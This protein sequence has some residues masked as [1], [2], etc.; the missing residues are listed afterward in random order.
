VLTADITAKVLTVSGATAS[1]KTYDGTTTATITG[2]T[3][4]GVVEGDTVSVS[5]GGTFASANVGNGIA[6]AAALSLS[7][8]DSG[9][10]SLTQPE[11]LSANITKAAQTITFSALAS[12]AVGDAPFALT[13]I[14]TSGLAVTYTSSNTG[15]ATIDGSTVT[16]VAAGTTVITASQAGDGNYEAATSVQQTLLVSTAIFAENLGTP[17]ATTAITTY[18]NGT[19]PATFQNKGTLTYSN[20]GQA[21]SADIRSTSASVAADYAGASGGGNAFFSSSTT[22]GSIGFAIEGINA[23]AYKNLSLTYSYRKTSSSVLPSLSVDYWNGNAWQ[24][25]ANTAGDL[26]TQASNASIKWYVA[27]SLSLPA[28]ASIN[29]L[30][31][32][33][34]KSGST[35][36]R[37]DDVKLNGVPK[38]VPVITSTPTASAITYGQTLADSVLSNGVADVAGTFA[39]TNPSTAPNAGVADYGVTFTPTDAAEYAAATL[40]VSVTVNAVSLAEEAITLNRSG[41]GYTA[42]ATGVSGFSYSYSGRNGTT[43]GPS[44]TAPSVAG[45]YTVTASSSDANYS[46]SK[47]ENYFVSGLIAA[48]DG[49]TKPADGSEVKIPLS[50]LLTNDKRIDGSGAVQTTGLTITGVTSGEGNTASIG[51]EFVLFVPS[52]SSPET[53]SYTLS[54]GT[55]TATGTVTVT[56]EGAAPTFTLQI[57]QPGT[58]VQGG[59]QTSVTHNFVGIPNQTLAIEYSTDLSTWHSTGNHSTGATGSFTVTVSAAGSHNWNS[60]FFRARY[61]ANP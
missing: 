40:N 22:N 19:A 24:T 41:N 58:P 47:S 1:N 45:F 15:V 43:Y 29:G 50:T 5:G 48:N 20:G 27:K 18:A 28:G 60:M 56:T 4:V 32:R 57:V 14:S 31:L 25:V 2:A 3:L 33:F 46:G 51:G 23:S 7:G 53:F 55:V 10:Y 13:A 39:F 9:N 54:D 26:F 6:V 42:S 8:A 38:I 59:G 30:K 44:S 34:V 35:E 36:I 52:E 11:G 21:A 61:V 49:V 12:K 17:S 37:I 16:L